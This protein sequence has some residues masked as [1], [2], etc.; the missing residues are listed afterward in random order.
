MRK[1]SLVFALLIA[2]AFTASAQKEQYNQYGV[3]VDIDPL[4]AEA[5]DGILVL[6]SKGDSGYKIWLDNRVQ[7]DGAIYFGEPEW[8]PK[9]DQISNG[10]QGPDRQELVWRS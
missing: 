5:Q 6:R 8:L 2:A 1:V 3:K 4:Q 7:T 9:N 10:R